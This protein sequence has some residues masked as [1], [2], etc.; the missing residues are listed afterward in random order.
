MM[1]LLDTL[2]VIA[3]ENAICLLLKKAVQYGTTSDID[4]K[5]KEAKELGLFPQ[6][7]NS[8]PQQNKIPLFELAALNKKHFEVIEYLLE[9]GYCLMHDN[10]N[11]E[12]AFTLRNDSNDLRGVAIIYKH[13]LQYHQNKSECEKTMKECLSKNLQP[14]FSLQLEYFMMLYFEQW[15]EET[16]VNKHK[17]DFILATSPIKTMLFIL[18]RLKTNTKTVEYLTNAECILCKVMLRRGDITAEDLEILG[19]ID[20][21]KTDDILTEYQD[22]RGGYSTGALQL[23]IRRELFEDTLHFLNKIHFT[24]KL[25]PNENQIAFQNCC[26]ILKAK[27]SLIDFSK[28]KTRREWSSALVCTRHFDQKG[29]E[30]KMFPQT[31]DKREINRDK[32]RRKSQI[33]RHMATQLFYRWK[34]SKNMKS[35]QEVQIMKVSLSS[36]DSL[37]FFAIAVNPAG[38]AENIVSSILSDQKKL[39]CQY[40]FENYGHPRSKRYAEKLKAECSD[41][42]LA[43]LVVQ[44]M[45]KSK[46]YLRF[47]GF[48]AHAELQNLR[49][50][51]FFLFP[52]GFTNKER[53]AEEF[54]C[55]FADFL[56]Y[57]FDKHCQLHFSIYGKKRPCIS[58]SGRMEASNITDYN[59]NFGYFWKH[60]IED[61]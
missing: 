44:K 11:M 37:Y 19:Q 8:F 7:R 20:N 42:N 28:K 51:I 18:E 17:L 55:D 26:Q 1:S 50:K 2:N 12:L 35:L 31:S 34:Y 38:V 23:A 48:P 60:G 61:Q 6:N 49:G 57:Y 30:K 14:Y 54:L 59:P 46:N 33:L 40:V 4:M 25:P 45:L 22:P 29:C 32:L 10:S 24:S 56:K 53:H 16:I 13:F 41:A 58:C 39:L 27:L 43:G 47:P 3:F 5:W 36:T 21:V 9:N 15:T 52:S